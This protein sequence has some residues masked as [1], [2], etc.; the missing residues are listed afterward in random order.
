RPGRATPPGPPGPPAG[1]APSPAP[2]PPATPGSGHQTSRESSPG[3]ATIA[4][5]RCPLRPGPGSLSN[6]HR[7]SSEGTFRVDAPEPTTIYTV[8]RGLALSKHSTSTR[9]T[10]P[11]PAADLRYL[12]RQTPRDPP[13]RRGA[14]PTAP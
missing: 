7:P 4:L 1:P 2:D 11:A 14:R 3:H 12:R 6:S 13:L 5:A 10:R 8:D 9:T